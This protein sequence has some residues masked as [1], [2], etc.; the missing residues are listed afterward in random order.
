MKTFLQ[1]SC[2]ALVVFLF[3]QTYET[4]N[5]HGISV[6]CTSDKADQPDCFSLGTLGGVNSSGVAFWV[7][8]FFDHSVAFPKLVSSTVRNRTFRTNS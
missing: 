3:V 6:T 4:A 8:T 2:I 5:A 7:T 1:T